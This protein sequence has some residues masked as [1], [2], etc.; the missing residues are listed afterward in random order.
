[1]KHQWDCTN[2]ADSEGFGY[3]DVVPSRRFKCRE[4][5][6]ATREGRK[7]YT[8]ELPIADDEYSQWYAI[9]E[10]L[11]STPENARVCLRIRTRRSLGNVGLASGDFRKRFDPILRSKDG[12][13]NRVRSM[14]LISNT[15]RKRAI[16]NRL[17][18]ALLA[19]T[20]KLQT[21]TVRVRARQQA[22]LS[23]TRAFQALH[24]FCISFS[25]ETIH[26]VS[27]HTP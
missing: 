13:W 25:C 12:Q 7:T 3:Y 2:G 18:L 11:E 20:R 10:A 19:R 24:P 17:L 23:R 21:E 4:H 14:C 27:I 26:S 15:L 5:A 9:A 16:L 1:M 6:D 8:P 22:S